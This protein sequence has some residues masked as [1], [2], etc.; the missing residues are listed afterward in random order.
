VLRLYR[1]VDA[2]VVRAATHTS[3][4]DV[5]PWPDLTGSTSEHVVQWRRWLEQ[6]WAQ[7]AIAASVEVA[8]P[9]LA[10]RVREVCAGRHHEARRVR[11]MVVSVARYL[12]RMTSRATPFGL[13]AGVAPA[14]FGS[15]LAVRYGEDHHAVARVDTE[16]LAG[17][18]TRLETCSELRRR[19]PVVLNNLG[20][21]KRSV[22]HYVK[23]PLGKGQVGASR[24]SSSQIV[25]LSPLM[26]SP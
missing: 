19:L 8:S 5:L 10:R 23:S 22:R 2:A 11:G 24:G 14:R 9:V 25:W 17:L 7:D 6:V 1:F 18:I 4:L 13:F 26:V 20:G 21:L 12:L 16:W 3:R 15:E